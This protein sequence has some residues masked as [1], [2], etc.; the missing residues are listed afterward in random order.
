MIKLFYLHFFL[1]I[2]IEELRAREKI[3]KRVVVRVRIRKINKMCEGV[4]K[5]L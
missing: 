4:E 3:E 1:E 5:M 2:K